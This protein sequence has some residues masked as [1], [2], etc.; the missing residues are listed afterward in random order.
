MLRDVFP[1]ACFELGIG[2]EEADEERRG[3]LATILTIARREADLE[4]VL[5][6]AVR[7]MRSHRL[8]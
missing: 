5:A 7:Q 2:L 3:Q 6:I 4:L 1:K 8:H